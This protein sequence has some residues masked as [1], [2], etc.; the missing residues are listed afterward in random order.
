MDDGTINRLLRAASAGDG[1]ALAELYE[2]TAKELY[3][4]VL[5]VLKDEG[6]AA[7]IVQDT[8]VQLLKV[9][10]PPMLRSGRAWMYR[11]AKNL[12]LNSV[13]R[14]AFE[15]PSQDT[16]RFESRGTEP[17]ALSRVYSGTVLSHLPEEDR[18]LV[19]LKA[20]SGFTFREISDMTGVPEHSLKRRIKRAYARLRDIVD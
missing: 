8:F 20:L 5:P 15:L 3:Y 13:K 10:P 11:I 12:S 9:P 18:K 14:A 19:L 7:D 6:R 17:D 1:D 2:G 16:S 4:F